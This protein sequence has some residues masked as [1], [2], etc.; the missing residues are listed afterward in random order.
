MNPTHAPRISA[1]T[2]LLKNLTAALH[3]PLPLT[4]GQS[5]TL[6]R[7]VQDSFR[8]HL[9]NESGAAHDPKAPYSSPNAHIGNILKMA[10]FVPS[11]EEAR[12]QRE[13]RIKRYLLDPVAVFE[14]HVALGTANL[15]LARSCLARYNDLKSDI[16][17][18]GGS[19]MLKGLVTA[20]LLEQPNDFLSHPSFSGHLM[21]AL[22]R[23]G[24]DDLLVRWVLERDGP[25]K[26]LARSLV[27]QIE[28]QISL[29]RAVQIFF[30][31]YGTLAV[32]TDTQQ[33]VQKLGVVGREL[34]AAAKKTGKL[35]APQ[36]AR[37]LATAD[38]WA[39]NRAEHAMIHL[40]F[41]E[42]VRPGLA[43][44]AFIDAKPAQWWADL[45]EKRRHRYAQMGIELA[46][47][48]L[49]QDNLADA[50]VVAEVMRRRFSEHLGVSTVP[51]QP[52]ESLSILRRGEVAEHL[53][54]FREMFK[55]AIPA[56][57]LA[58]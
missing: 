13:Q 28:K 27:R 42:S 17:E 43:F 55:D 25:Q 58:V 19:R 26:T 8:Q 11:P 48:C 44:I 37:L 33:L 12:K 30:K 54:V 41:G 3:P 5:H 39:L 2:S 10:P 47:R 22:A 53:D 21:V 40:R 31:F 1:A 16:P 15:E 23:E 36:F 24:K 45:P 29:E 18:S 35:S 14:E 56:E 38:Q 4:P 49:A 32:S 51:Q 7:A 50:K 57:K 34:C 52:R 46:H 6:L 20:G 9:A